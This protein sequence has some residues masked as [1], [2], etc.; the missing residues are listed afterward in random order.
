MY[1]Y[2]TTDNIGTSSNCN[3]LLTMIARLLQISI[4]SI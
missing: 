3:G 4:A 1:S 2:L